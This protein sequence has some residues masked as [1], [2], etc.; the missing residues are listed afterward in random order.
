MDNKFNE[1]DL[2]R[3]FFNRFKE[4][5]FLCDQSKQFYGKTPQ[6]K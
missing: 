2:D 6:F 3:M 1:L 4:Q 5:F